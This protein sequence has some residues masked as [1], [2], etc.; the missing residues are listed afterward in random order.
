MPQALFNISDHCLPQ[1]R[2]IFR[3][4]NTAIEKLGVDADKFDQTFRVML[5][6]QCRTAAATGALVL[7]NEMRAEAQQNI[8]SPEQIA[9]DLNS[10][11]NSK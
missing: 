8:F 2:E 6:L 4:I 3:A 10:L 5:M 7:T 9:S 11:E 1:Q